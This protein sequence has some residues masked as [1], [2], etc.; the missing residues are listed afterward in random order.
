MACYR[1]SRPGESSSTSY[2]SSRASP[3]FF[4]TDRPFVEL[5]DRGLEVDTAMVPSWG[6]IYQGG[7]LQGLMQL[8][9]CPGEQVLYVGDHIYGDIVSSKLESTW[10]TALIVRELEEEITKRHQIA[11]QIL[12]DR[13]LKQRLSDLGTEMDHLRD[14]IV[15]Y[16]HRLEQNPGNSDDAYEGLRSRYEDVIAEHRQVLREQA[17][18]ADQTARQF[19]PYWGSFFKQGTSKTRFSGQLETY[20]CLYTSRVSNFAYYGSNHYFRV[21][22]DP[23]MH[24][25]V[26]RHLP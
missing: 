26:G 8:I 5:D 2:W 3:E 7:S 16:Q 6:H 11:D 17:H 23:M 10:R 21:T 20:S 18:W 1:D 12:R 25:I 19:N 9:D 4:R 14:L 24:E 13:E 15:L 22:R